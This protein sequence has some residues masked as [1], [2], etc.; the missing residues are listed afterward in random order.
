M[1]LEKSAKDLVEFYLSKEESNGQAL[2]E[3]IDSW[4]MESEM[5]E[6]SNLQKFFP[7]D[8]NIHGVTS[9]EMQ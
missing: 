6:P 7:Q 4:E 1:R 8:K 9:E 2:W 5:F 3:Q